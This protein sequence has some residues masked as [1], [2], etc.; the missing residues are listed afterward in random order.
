MKLTIGLIYSLI[1]TL[2]ILH[3]LSGF[4]GD[5]LA[6]AMG[7]YLL[8]NQNYHAAITEYQRALFFYPN[9]PW[10]AYLWIQ[11][12]HANEATG[13]YP[14]AARFYKQAL[15]LPLPQRVKIKIRFYLALDY[16]L[17]GKTSLANLEFSKLKH[18]ASTQQARITF[19]AFHLMT[20]I[21]QNQWA[22]AQQVFQQLQV[23][24]KE[25]ENIA[26]PLNTIERILTELAEHPKLKSPTIARR[27]ST[28]LPGAGQVY[29]GDWRNGL[30]ALILNV[31]TTYLLWQ[32]IAIQSYLDLILIGSF[33]WW[34]YYE[35]NRVRTTMIVEEKNNRYLREQ[36]QQLLNALRQIGFFLPNLDLEIRKSELINQ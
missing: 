1:L 36:K 21:V 3:P 22:Q 28:I 4:S 13:A 5:S 16:L 33:V 18:T 30:N 23:Y 7:D 31:G 15:R 2:G 19:T 10:K 8:K 26:A 11:M 29:A 24:W 9:T 25:N 20:L 12:A 32:S 34:R 14:N 35:G 17:A 6:V 27:L